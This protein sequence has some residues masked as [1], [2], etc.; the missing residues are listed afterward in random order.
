MTN[1]RYYTL[2]VQITAPINCYLQFGNCTKGKIFIGMQ[3]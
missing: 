2:I 3:T 1:S